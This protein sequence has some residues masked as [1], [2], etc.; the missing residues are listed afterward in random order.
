MATSRPFAYNPSPNP[1][2]A[3]TL[4]VGD[5]AVGVDPSL[6]YYGGVGGVQWWQGP[7]E[8][9][10]YIVAKPVPSLNQPNP[11]NIAAGVAFGRSSFTEQAF[12]ALA[13][14][15]SSGTT[16]STG[17]EAS[18]WLTN[19]G[20]WNTWVFITPTQTPT[21]TPTPTVTITP[22]VTPSITPTNTPTPSTAPQAQYY[23]YEPN[24]WA[25]SSV[26]QGGADNFLYTSDYLSS[27]ISLQSIDYTTTNWSFSVWGLPQFEYGALPVT[28]IL[29]SN[30]IS[31][32]VPN[33][34]Y[35]DQNL[36]N[37]TIAVEYST[38]GQTLIND[39]VVFMRDDLNRYS[40]WSWAINSDPNS[41]ITGVAPSVMWDYGNPGSTLNIEKFSNIVITHDHSIT[42]SNASGSTLAYWNGSLLTL[43]SYVQNDIY[44]HISDY[45]ALTKTSLYIANGNFIDMTVSLHPLSTNIDNPIYYPITTLGSNGAAALYNN[46]IVLPTIVGATSDAYI[47]NFDNVSANHLECLDQNN[48]TVSE[49][50]LSQNSGGGGTAAFI[51][52]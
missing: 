47:W 46:G 43:K 38:S 9:L 51:L 35:P 31:L 14:S 10:G 2:I 39:L 3:G 25:P 5:I 16:F 26:P 42:N 22:T 21:N 20:Y 40:K 4:Q 37:L 12:I 36:T 49:L 50:G 27:A 8:D 17:N 28:D 13:E 41:N 24:S 19:N 33:N 52:I 1:P 34:T 32:S 6:D 30:L 11:L 7:D 15:L 29:T 48:I 23:F 18:T 44:P 45:S